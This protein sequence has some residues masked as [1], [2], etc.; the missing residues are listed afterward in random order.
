M[1]TPF[2]SVLPVAV[3][4]LVLGA[5]A[6]A[7]SCASGSDTVKAVTNTVV[8]TVTAPVE[9]T[10]NILTGTAA[11]GDYTTDAPGVKRKITPADLPKPYSTESANNGPKWAAKPAGA[12]PKVPAGFVAS[13][14]AGGLDNPRYVTTAP[15][16]DTFIVESNPG[17]VKVLRDTNN[18]GKSDETIT[19]A[20]GFTRPF[21]LAFYPANDPNPKYVYVANTGSVV[22][23]AYK[24]GDSKATGTA[25]MIVDNI[26]TGN[27]QVGGGGH[28]T[29]DIAFS[30]DNKTMFVSVGSRSN[31][32]D[33]PSEDRRAVILS[34]TPDGK[35][36]SIYASGIRNP[37][38]IAI[39]PATGKLWTSVNERDQLGDNLVPDYVTSVK[40]GGFY[41]WPWYYM[42]A[43]QDPRHDGKKPEL[44]DTVIVPDVL[45]QPHSASLGLAFYNGK[46]FPKDYTGNIFAAEHGS[47]NRTKRTGY[48]VVRVP[49]KNGVASGYYEDFMTGF[50]ND[51]GNVWGRPVAVAVAKDGALLVTDDN[52]G[53]VWR[54]AY[55]K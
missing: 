21:G 25:E 36:E 4:V 8:E 1:K 19:F 29:R 24:N 38:G 45:I 39:E 42:G 3:G 28:W 31:V 41:G 53:T 20:E 26:P 34:F 50:V 30:R 44:K 33:G 49:V 16:G 48:K 10:A 6:I 46:Q 51:D 35:N 47:W 9:T 54:V 52:S 12:L 13:E 14:F 22:R 55:K 37:V 23:Y 2:S 7:V 11:F 5:G 40:Q 43:N 32:S 15:N 17:R 27:E 18:D